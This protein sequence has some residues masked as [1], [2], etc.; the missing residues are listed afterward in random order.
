VVTLLRDEQLMPPRPKGMGRGFAMAVVAHVLLVIA[1]TV[2]V[3]WRSSEP[4]GVEAE[5][6]AAVPQ[7]AAP[8]AAEPPPP[9]PPKPQPPQPK[10]EP[11]V[12]P[13]PKP[14]QPDPQIAIEQEKKRKLEQQKREQEEKEK[15]KDKAEKDK[16]EKDKAE[17]LKTEKA[18][19]DKKKKE[20]AQ[21]QARLDAQRKANL[22][23]MMAQAGNGDTPGATAQQTAGPSSSYGGRI[24]AR[25]KPNI[26]FTDSIAGNPTADVEVRSAPDGTI[27]STKLIK[28]S[29]VAAWDDAVLRALEKTQVLPR[30]TDGRVQSPMILSFRPNDF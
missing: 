10:P 25:V 18:E 15:A 2:G 24:R 11:R 28:S 14:A 17:K 16:A 3:N 12:E 6:W 13:P 9:E 8:P 30:D 7:L 27:L 5:L 19:A 20:E 26:T 4:A 22:D 1:L 21:Q 23:R 29:G